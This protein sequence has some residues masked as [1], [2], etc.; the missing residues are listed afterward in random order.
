[1]VN[2]NTTPAVV[3]AT[4]ESMT[5]ELWTHE[6][7]VLLNLR[8]L[9]H[10]ISQPS[11]ARLCLCAMKLQS[12]DPTVLNFCTRWEFF[13]R[14]PLD[15][16]SGGPQSRS[17]SCE[18]ARKFC[19]CWESNPYISSVHSAADRYTDWAI[20][21]RNYTVTPQKIRQEKTRTWDSV[22]SWHRD[23]TSVCCSPF[24]RLSGQTS[25]RTLSVLS[26]K[27]QRTFFFVSVR[28]YPWNHAIWCYHG[29]ELSSMNISYLIVHGQASIIFSVYRVYSVSTENIYMRIF[30]C[31]ML[32]KRDG[33]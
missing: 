18:K 3:K 11:S 14:Y 5:L 1:M 27:T 7:E 31:S 24:Q 19:R 10:R 22:S 2:V 15:M 33:L 8:H 26:L 20:V 6:P 30:E 21:A 4:G 9:A 25:F 23:M 17:G 29:N 32:Y 13:P 12:T 16:L 28:R